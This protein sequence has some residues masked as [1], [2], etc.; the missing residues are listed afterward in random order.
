MKVIK[1]YL[2]IAACASLVLLASSC[3]KPQQHAAAPIAKQATAPAIAAPVQRQT[4]PEKTATL[5]PQS[6]S[7]PT[8]EVPQP[9][10]DPVADL[11]S[12]VETEYQAGQQN[13]KAGNEDAAKLNFDRA[14]NLLM[15]SK[16]D[17]HSD[18]RLEQEYN[19][20]LA[21]ENSLELQALQQTPSS[22]EQK[23]EPAPID[24]ANETTTSVNP[25]VRAKAEAEIK[26]TH[27]DLPLM[28][29][30]PVASYIDYFSNRG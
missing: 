4:A 29:T 5:T 16:L 7:P 30:D 20:V 28:M 2:L 17:M 13:F 18:Q 23:A 22:N 9:K 21:G 1:L 14:F 25:N 3:G 12:K 8:A 26:A 15:N 27:S 11:I 10:V 24:E 19:K 6:Q